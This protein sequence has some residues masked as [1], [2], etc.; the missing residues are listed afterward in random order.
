MRLPSGEIN[1]NER[2]SDEEIIE[3]QE[4]LY[5]LESSAMASPPMN[6]LEQI[7]RI[8]AFFSKSYLDE[9]YAKFGV[10]K[11]EQPKNA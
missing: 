2:W 8:K 1:M 3:Y 7:S 9:L 10:D 5:A 11:N 6:D 4:K